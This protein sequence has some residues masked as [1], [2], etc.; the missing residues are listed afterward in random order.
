M[1]FF[2]TVKLHSLTEDSTGPFINLS[3]EL[4]HFPYT[5][6]YYWTHYIHNRCTKSSPT[7]STLNRCHHQ[8]VSTAITIVFLLN[9]VHTTL[10]GLY[11]YLAF[12]MAP[13][14][15][16]NHLVKT[17]IPPV[18][19]YMECEATSLL[20]SNTVTFYGWFLLCFNRHFN[21]CAGVWLCCIQRTSRKHYFTHRK[22]PL[23]LATMECRNLYHE[24]LC[25]LFESPAS[26]S[27][28]NNN[29]QL[30]TRTI[31]FYKRTT[32]EFETI[33][34]PVSTILCTINIR[35][36]ISAT[37]MANVATLI[38]YVTTVRLTTTETT[39]VSD[40]TYSK[41]RHM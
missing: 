30:K 26:L 8:G 14:T 17:A 21:T 1:Q 34:P 27:A 31:S 7:V 18:T 19:A 10:P 15:I 3:V 6:N 23:V 25:I 35:T 24:I 33:F 38:R 40:A 12:E 36:A 37:E 9:T 22:D 39:H 2:Y 11:P 28:S 4:H 32:P 29:S 16:A 41:T 20:S 5:E 13:A